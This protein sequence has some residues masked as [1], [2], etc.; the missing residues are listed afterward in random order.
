MR[1]YT[2]DNV[3]GAIERRLRDENFNVKHLYRDFREDW[4]DDGGYLIAVS[5]KNGKYYLHILD[6]NYNVKVWCHILDESDHRLID[7]SANKME[8]VDYIVCESLEEVQ[9]EIVKF[10][11]LLDFTI[12]F[13][14]HFSTY[15]YE[16][17]DLPKEL[18]GLG[19]YYLNMLEYCAFSYS[20]YRDK[21]RAAIL[22]LLNT[23]YKPDYSDPGEYLGE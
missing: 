2:E 8:H 1:K 15:H 4:G 18:R 11:D 3:Y 21:D 14:E 19:K 9:K 16:I 23:E 5:K 7:G 13:D 17:E 6:V 10:I 12:G 20:E 22:N